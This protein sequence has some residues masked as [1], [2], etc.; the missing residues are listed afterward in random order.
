MAEETAA[1]RALELKIWGADEHGEPR[2][3]LISQCAPP[4]ATPLSAEQEALVLQDRYEQINML[5]P[6][7]KCV[8]MFQNGVDEFPAQ[9]WISLKKQQVARERREPL[10]ERGEIRLLKTGRAD[11]A[12]LVYREPFVPTRPVHLRQSDY[13]PK[14]PRGDER[15]ANAKDRLRKKLEER[16]KPEQ[17]GMPLD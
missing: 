10:P 7:S 8:R 2:Y 3:N 1:D 4:S 12:P 16:Q 15:A 14:P 13:K 5:N 6:P 9:E 17:D 11:S